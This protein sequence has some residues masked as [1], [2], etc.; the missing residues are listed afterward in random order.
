MEQKS[1]ARP[2]HTLATIIKRTRIA[3]DGD[4]SVHCAGIVIDELALFALSGCFCC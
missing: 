3:D 1:N 4:A 2:T